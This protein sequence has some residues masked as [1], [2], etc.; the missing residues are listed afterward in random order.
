M[1]GALDVTLTTGAALWPV[2]AGLTVVLWS[3]ARAARPLLAHSRT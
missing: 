1:S 2:L 3:K